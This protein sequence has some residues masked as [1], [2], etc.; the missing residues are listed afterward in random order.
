MGEK[1]TVTNVDKQKVQGGV[2]MTMG[3]A[4]LTLALTFW[5]RIQLARLGH[6]PIFTAE[7]SL[8]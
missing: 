5:L 3:V 4:V 2:I 6:Q 7:T 8:Q 1:R